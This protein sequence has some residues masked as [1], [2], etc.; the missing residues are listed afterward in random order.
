MLWK[1]I[2][3]GGASFFTARRAFCIVPTYTDRMSIWYIISGMLCDNQKN[4]FFV[5]LHHLKAHLKENKMHTY[6][7]FQWN[8]YPLQI[9]NTKISKFTSIFCV[10]N[11]IILIISQIRFFEYFFRNLRKKTHWFHVLLSHKKWISN[12]TIFSIRKK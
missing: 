5:R 2:I 12:F 9:S 7:Y 1:L 10:F 3:F 4:I 11:Q 8:F 6:F